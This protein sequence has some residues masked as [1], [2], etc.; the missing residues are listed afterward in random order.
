[1]DQERW[2]STLALTQASLYT[3]Q[4]SW[5]NA[6]AANLDTFTQASWIPQSLF[7]IS[8]AGA[9][10]TLGAFESYYDKYNSVCNIMHTGVDQ[11]QPTMTF[12]IPTIFRFLLSKNIPVSKYSLLQS[13][14]SNII[15]VNSFLPPCMHVYII[16]LSNINFVSHFHMY[17]PLFAV[18]T[19]SACQQ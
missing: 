5:G 12:L 7:Y 8:R 16:Q 15:P 19:L 11:D 14:Y 4:E 13:P 10:G 1:M 3:P 17:N 2:D 18:T 9:L 6:A